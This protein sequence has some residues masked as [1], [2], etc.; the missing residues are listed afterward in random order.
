MSRPKSVSISFILQQLR[1]SHS[2]IE[3]MQYLVEKYSNGY[4]GTE[5][6]KAERDGV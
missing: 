5:S 6:F 1:D 2:A 3:D 4:E